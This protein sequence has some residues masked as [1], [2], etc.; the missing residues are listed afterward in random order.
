M[1]DL[2][3]E[4]KGSL[5]LLEIDLEVGPKDLKIILDFALEEGPKDSKTILELDLGLDFET[6]DLEQIMEIAEF[7][8]LQMGP[9]LGLS[10]NHSEEPKAMVL[11][12]N[13]GSLEV[14]VV[15]V[16]SQELD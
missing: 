7:D 1:E 5:V 9:F 13:F 12:S 6:I 4:Q 3:V 15:A 14:M 11:D 10:Y 16:E 2:E 8:S